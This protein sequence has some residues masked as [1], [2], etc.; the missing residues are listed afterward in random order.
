[1]SALSDR[2]ERDLEIRGYAEKTRKMY[3]YHVRLFAKHYMKSPDTLGVQE[4]YRYQQHLIRERKVSYSYFN[5]AVQA[6]RFFYGKTVRVSWNI[7]MLPFHK[8]HRTMPVVLS[9]EEVSALF[10]AAAFPKHRALLKA[11]YSSGLRLNEAR[12]LRLVDID[13]DR[14]VIHVKKAKGGKERYVMLARLLW[15]ELRAYLGGKNPP[16]GACLF[17]GNDPDKPLSD[18]SIQ[19]VIKTAARR[20]GISK[21]VTPHTLRH[22]FATHLLESGTNIRVIQALLGHRS[23]NTTA[24]YTHV[25]KNGPIETRSPLDGL[26]PKD[27]PDK[28]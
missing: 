13:S 15:E 26:L 3:L 27:K 24:I 11:M 25:A 23:L 20:A 6:L 4:V 16:T 12:Q 7:N 10:D 5:Q 2:M 14:M 19:K 21:R 8:K 17:P 18:R 9:V 22:S 28:A 1:M